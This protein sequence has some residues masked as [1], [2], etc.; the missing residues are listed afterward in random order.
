MGNSRRK[1]IAT[2]D[3]D[4]RTIWS[5]AIRNRTGLSIKRA[6]SQD[7]V[8]SDH[9]RP[10]LTLLQSI[11]EQDSPLT[12][13]LPWPWLRT[14]SIHVPRVPARRRNEAAKL[15]LEPTLPERADGIWTDALTVESEQAVMVSACM[16]WLDPF[17]Q[18]KRSIGF[19]PESMAAIAGCIEAAE[20]M[21]GWIVV[22]GRRR[23]WLGFFRA[24]SPV[25]LRSLGFGSDNLDDPSWLAGTR[26]LTTTLLTE[27]NERVTVFSSRGVEIQS[28]L[29][30]SC[31][32]VSEPVRVCPE[33]VVT[34]GTARIAL[35]MVPRIKPVQLPL[36]SSS[37]TTRALTWAVVLS[38]VVATL[39][40]GDLEL[41]NRKSRSRIS[42]LEAAIS[43]KPPDVETI[44]TAFPVE[45]IGALSLTVPRDL[46]IVL[47]RLHM[48]ESTLEIEGD[49]VGFTAVDAMGV[50]LGD[51]PGCRGVTL[52]KSSTMTGGRVEF[53]FRCEI[54][55]SRS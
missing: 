9:A 13:A 50:L 32:P 21:E 29:P 25:K 19:V 40:I 47:D 46:D 30:H 37:S 7:S 23:C 43:A 34:L 48:T 49:A 45:L 22:L 12:L 20:P 3:T 55:R 31:A 54:A 35:G 6:N 44:K 4:G 38:A 10:T 16:K 5:I 51:L 28:L 42:Q 2:V 8:E 53:S 41:R 39:T 1:L 18:L 17:M 27:P 11:P 26:A 14:H 36:P 52:I 24:G 15:R 33:D